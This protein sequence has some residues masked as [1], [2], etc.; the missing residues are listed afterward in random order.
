MAINPRVRDIIDLREHM[1]RG[2]IRSSR[3]VDEPAA[4]GGA[5]VPA[6]QSSLKHDNISY[7]HILLTFD[8]RWKFPERHGKKKRSFKRP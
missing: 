8:V 1:E 7:Y 3:Y 4:G 5:S 6:V 2:N